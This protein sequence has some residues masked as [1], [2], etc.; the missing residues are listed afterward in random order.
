M[1]LV[2]F[3]D[4]RDRLTEG[5]IRA[6]EKLGIDRAMLYRSKVRRVSDPEARELLMSRHPGD[7]AGILYPYVNP[8]TGNNWTWR[9]RRDHPEIEKGKPKDKYLAAHGDPRHLFFPPDCRDLLKDVAVPVY[10][11]EAEKSALAI[12]CAGARE[13]LVVVVIGL[14]GCWGWRGTIGKTE[15]ANGARVDEKGPLS[16]FDRLAWPERDV[17]VLFD[18]NAATNEKVQQARR[19]LVTELSGRGAN[20]RIAALPVEDGVNGPD[21]YIWKHGDAALFAL[22]ESESTT[23]LI[24][25]PADPLPSARAFLKQLHIV[26][27]VLALRHQSSVFYEYEPSA[28]HECDEASIRAGLY[29]FLEKSQRWTDGKPAKLV[30]FQPNRAKVENVLDAMRALCNL[31]A[32]SAAPCWLQDDPGRNPFDLLAFLNGI[33]HIPTRTLLPATPAFFT[34][35]GL[36]FDFDPLAPCPTNWLTFLNVLW[37]NDP[38]SISTLQEWIGYNLTP[39]TRFQKIAM[40]I[41]PKRSGKGTIGRVIRR[42]LGDRNVCGPTLANVGE[43]FG[44]SILIGKSAAIV[45]D[46]RI[47]GRTDTSIVTERLLSISGEDTLSIPRKYL[48][49]WT[50]KLPTRFLLLTN[51]LPR[52][53]DSSGALTSRFLVLALDQSFYGREDHDL[54]DRFV[55][56]L[57]GILLWALAGYDRLYARS[58]FVQPKSSL[59]LI[60]QFENLGSP[61]G[62]FLR[63]RC[64]I[65]R[66]YEVPQHDLFEAW[67]N[68]CVEVGRERPGTIQTFG[69]NLRAA[70]PWLGES[71]PY[72]EGKRVRV[73]VGLRIRQED[74]HDDSSGM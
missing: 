30:P 12:T 66:G 6:H 4:D 32:T 70:V 3:A 43:Q 13:G 20:V 29:V 47:G 16:D 8:T 71:Q 68:W 9:L 57:P 2:A 1:T 45:A 69:R 42:L 65:D 10:C 72:L 18:A 7:L 55:P 50:G 34:L 61:I 22:V 28:Y 15:D 19:A 67:R 54:F 59:E 14:G 5:D 35:A 49:D 39:Q 24:L 53:E 11:V 62:A 21:D 31:P 26:D 33:L 27:G 25:N 60:Q 56:E 38:E 23:G 58:R 40:I 44:L 51:E 17:V 48:P 64:D 73:Y 52:I 46:A 37:P 36:D 74:G 41:G 63:E